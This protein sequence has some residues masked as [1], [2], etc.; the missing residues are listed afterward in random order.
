[1]RTQG[2][3]E[4]TSTHPANSTSF[5]EVLSALRPFFAFLCAFAS[6]LCLEA[7]D[8]NPRP[9]HRADLH[10]VPQQ[11]GLE[12]ALR[13]GVEEDCHLG[14]GAAPF[15]AGDDAGTEAHVAHALT[16]R[17]DQRPGRP[18]GRG[19]GAFNSSATP[20][21]GRARPRPGWRPSAP[22]YA[23]T[24]LRTFSARSRAAASR[25]ISCDFCRAGPA[26]CPKV[27]LARGQDA[28]QAVH[29][30]D[31]FV[32]GVDRDELNAVQPAQLDAGLVPLLFLQDLPVG[33][34]ALAL[35]RQADEAD[36]DA[37]I[38]VSTCPASAAVS[39]RG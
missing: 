2:M 30:L 39:W 29:L 32:G 1:M 8:K 6:N 5:E 21:L 3:A 26:A 38:R 15:D 33:L 9:L 17:Q 27:R 24:A 11:I 14:A 23:P 36:G 22:S 31:Y 16:G 25:V 4:S 20:L 10:L 13:G 34:A 28:Q 12:S 37:G 18:G 19:A 35:R 7:L